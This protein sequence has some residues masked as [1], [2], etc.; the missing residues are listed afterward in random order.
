MQEFLAKNIRNIAV[1]GHSGEGKTTLCEAILF[2]SGAVNRQGKIDDGNTVMDYDGE[3]ILRRI[4]ISLSMGCCTYEGT[5]INLIDVPGFFD[6]EGELI[7]ALSAADSA[8]IVTSAC[9]AL[10]VGCEKALD[11]CIKNKIPSMIFINQMD[12][13]NA[14]YFATINALKEKYKTKIAPTQIPVM[15]NQKMQGYINAVDARAYEFGSHG[16]VP[17]EI[18]KELIKDYDEV[19]E[20]LIEVAAE[21]DDVLLER[22]FNNQRL[23]QEEISF[24]I[25]KGISGGAAIPVLAGSALMNR[26]IFNLMHQINRSMPNPEEG[27]PQY[28]AN[29][30][31][32]RVAVACDKALPFSA[33]VFK[34]IADPYVGKLSLIRVI[35]GSLKS[36][37]T[38]SNTASETQEKISG[39]FFLRG[40]TQEVADVVSAGDIVALSK[41]LYTKTLDTLCDPSISIKFDRPSMPPAVLS[42]AVYAAKKGEEEKIFA[43]LHKLNEEDISFK[44]LKDNETGETLLSGLGETQLDVTVKKLRAKYGAE[45]TLSL[46][47]IAYRETIKK[48]V[49]A[50]GKHKK[51]SGGAGQYGHCFIRFE[52]YLEG[53]FAFGD[54]VVGGTV[55][56]QYIPAVEKG[57]REAI[58]KGVLAGYPVVNLKAVVYDGS[59]HSVDSKEIAY[60]T[61][62]FLAY[63]DGLARANPVL[64]EPI[65]TLTITVNDN[66][67]GDI[68]GDLNRRRG[69]ILGVESADGMQV[70]RADLPLSEILRYATDLRSMTQGRGSY[71]SER[72]RYEEVPPANAAKIID[73]AKI[74]GTV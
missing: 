46:P 32:E 18:P 55:P 13:E 9:G 23:S 28:A 51:Q 67:L 3:E 24:G 63:K 4:S 31:N 52:P 35:S 56:R 25:K 57:V 60:K 69:R 5:K 59:S 43:G 22:F 49:T 20:H 14:D 74:K 26:G 8:I 15:R 12:K 10:T 34:T 44:I 2:N 72:A 7:Q 11:F 50:E 71:T 37:A 36:G 17:L 6:F 70:I 33:R 58:L 61:A 42:T 41:L 65:E 47:K 68:L 53:D 16:K 40:K 27:H 39:M 21:C 1:I 62:A 66:F 54:E 73:A 64:L 30:K 45:A 48:I 29:A 38:V 19:R